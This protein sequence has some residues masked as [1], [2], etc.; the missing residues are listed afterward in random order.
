[1]RRPAV[2]TKKEKKPY[3]DTSSCADRR[4]VDLANLAGSMIAAMRRRKS[5]FHC[6]ATWRYEVYTI[7]T[8]YLLPAMYHSY[9][10]WDLFL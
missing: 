5:R 2:R 1:M 10:L 4:V 9:H 6:S 8:T 7:I 3:S